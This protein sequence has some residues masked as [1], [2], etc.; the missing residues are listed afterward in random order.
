MESR[1]VDRVKKQRNQHLIKV[2]HF[3]NVEQIFF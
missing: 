2:H 1:E 3:G